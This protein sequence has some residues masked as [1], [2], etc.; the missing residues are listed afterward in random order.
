M[1]MSAYETAPFRAVLAIA[2]QRRDVDVDRCRVVIELLVA[3]GSIHSTFRDELGALELSDLDFATL[4]TLYAILP[5]RAT[6]AHLA[7]QTGAAR[8]SMTEASDR[9]EA[10]GL[11][12]RERDTADRRVVFIMLTEPGRICVEV[13]M[14]RV[15]KKADRIGRML[16]P[17]VRQA[18]VDECGRL[19]AAARRERPLPPRDGINVLARKPSSASDATK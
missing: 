10:R 16:R 13:A 4:V 7:A 15:L 6:L 9:L 14:D 12:H 17:H 18:F 19:E 8:P 3:G 1:S 11:V 5:E 2:S